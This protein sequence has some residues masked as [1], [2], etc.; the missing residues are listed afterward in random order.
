MTI[1]ATNGCF[2]IFHAGHVQFLQEAKSLGDKLVVG[3]NSDKSVKKLKGKARPFNNQ[4]NR[5]IVLSALEC[6]DE[7]IVFDSINCSIF[8][9]QVKPD[10]YVKG[11]DYKLNQLPKCEKEAL[12]KFCKDIRSLKR[13]DSLSTSDIGSEVFKERHSNYK[14]DERSD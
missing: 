1:V 5:E 4:K 7:V 2:D 10:I 9:E 13:Y 11:G 6:V 8:L 12:E 14:K 3:L